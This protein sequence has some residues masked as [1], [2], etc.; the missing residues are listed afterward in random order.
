MKSRVYAAGMLSLFLAASSFAQPSAGYLDI[1]IFHVKPEKRSEFDALAKKIA[2]IQ[3]K[4]KGDYWTAAET[5]YGEQNTIYISSQR[6]SYAETDKAMSAFEAAMAKA[7]GA[8]AGKFFQDLNNCLIST[9]AEMRLRRL[10]LSR[11]A[12]A[13][14]AAR[15]KLLGS[16]RYRS[17]ERR[18]GKE[19]RSRWSPYH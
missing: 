7:L 13:D 11:N 5:L 6:A 17:E 1:S 9:R 4:Q 16:A 10:D 15:A 8:G 2:E 14:A 12:P 3:R 18:V 19:C